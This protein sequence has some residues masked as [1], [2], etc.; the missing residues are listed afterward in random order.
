VR[1]EA[2]AALLARTDRAVALLKAVQSGEIQAASL[3]TAQ[4]NFLRN[5][6]DHAV[7][8]LAGQVLGAKPAGQRQSVIDVYLPALH[9]NGDAG[10]GRKVYEERCISCH[11][12]A[13]QGHAVG[14]DLITVKNSGKEK[15]MV[16]ILDPNREVRPDYVTYVVET[17]DG[18][19]LVGLIANETSTSVTVRQA[20][21]KEDVVPRSRIRRMR[22]QGQSLMPEGLEAGLTA[23]SLA[24]LL[25]FIETAEAGK[26]ESSNTATHSDKP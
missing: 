11:R 3:T 16:N 7:S 22:S 5:H 20:Y 4:A 6:R 19:S 15:L 25:E 14:P 10:R 8:Q 23:Q 18:E 13:G 17:E 21:G 12:I 26:T 1:S 2:I 9:L 24:D